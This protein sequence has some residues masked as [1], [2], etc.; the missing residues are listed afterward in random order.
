MAAEAFQFR[1]VHRITLES[2]YEKTYEL[3]S[4]STKKNMQTAINTY[5]NYFFFFEICF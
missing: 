1:F 2:T 4:K 5:E 3:M